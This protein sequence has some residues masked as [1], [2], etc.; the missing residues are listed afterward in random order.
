MDYEKALEFVERY[1]TNSWNNLLWLLAIAFGVIGILMPIFLQWIQN[2]S[3]KKEI[4]RVNKENKV[5]FEKQINEFK[6]KFKKIETNLEFLQG[7]TF[8]AQGNIMMKSNA[9]P[10]QILY[11]F[12]YAAYSFLMANNEMNL[13]YV[14]RTI[15]S[16]VHLDAFPKEI[17]VIDDGMNVREIYDRTV[18]L[19]EKK[20]I[21][22]NYTSIISLLKEKIKFKTEF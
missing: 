12:L 3:N 14:I 11:T 20:N 6:E 5:L 19:F 17:N 4:E 7:T 10:E 21:D 22:G 9:S 18:F 13:N 16:I 8:V 2:Q 15:N 1:Y